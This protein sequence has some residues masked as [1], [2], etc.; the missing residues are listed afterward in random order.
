M[1]GNRITALVFAVLVLAPSGA[2]AQAAPNPKSFAS[3]AD[4]QALIARAKAMPPQPLISQPMVGTGN[5]S[6]NLDYRAATLPA[7]IH[8]TEAELFYVIDGTG[9]LTMGGTLVEGKRTNPTNL[10]GS[11]IAG[12]TPI[13][14]AK[15]DFAIAPAGVAHQLAPD[16]G[17]V[18]VVMTFHVPSPW[19]GK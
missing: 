6:V 17:S 15:G 4:I 2:W 7:A 1:H 14:I 5:Y 10:S 11:S 18:L 19:P 13:R 16:S 9:I 3:S 12:G 8:D